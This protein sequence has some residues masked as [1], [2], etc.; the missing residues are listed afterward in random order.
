[1]EKKPSLNAGAEFK[2]GWWREVITRRDTHKSG[3]DFDAVEPTAAPEV[4][5]GPN[6]AMAVSW[7]I[8]VA[9][10]WAWRLLVIVA[11]LALV[12]FGMTKV[13]IIFV[14]LAV[15]LLMTLLLEPLHFWLQK[16][17]VPKTL[18]AVIS[19][20]VGVGLVAAIVS[21]ATTQLASGA[22]ALI[23]KAAGG[24]DKLI[25]WLSE[26][27]LALDQ[28]DIDKYMS[29]LYAQ[30]T[31]LITKYSTSIAS[32]ALSVTSSVVSVVTTLL[33]SLFC[34]FFFLKDGR[35][36][37]IWHIRMLPVPAR[38]PVHEA[39]IR[40]WT[41]LKGYIRAQAL[42]ALV[43][44]VF[45]SL[46][47]AILGAGSMTI[48]LA[49]L[50]FIGSFIPIVG[51]LT[52]GTIAVLILLLDK[53]LMAAIIMLIVILAVQQIEGNVLQPMLMSTAVSLH[54]LAVLLAVTA[55]T[56]L[57]GIIGALM[58]VPVVAFVNTVAL[59]LTG[60]DSMPE[61][62]KRHDRIGGP[63]GTI[64]AQVAMSY[65]SGDKKDSKK[66]LEAQ[67]RVREAADAAV[68]AAA[69]DAAPSDAAGDKPTAPEA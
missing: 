26:G 53:G 49:L 20:I 13:S 9:A 39:A 68:A 27:P 41:T 22:P 30:V 23:S 61:M 21:I 40:G 36:I 4:E 43:D 35:Q 54:P 64:H 24:F 63:P 11:L 29:Q 66:V 48:P 58:A 59:Y 67:Q 37:W 25:D 8:R 16:V 50:I 33:L 12:I 57:G 19:L 44:S 46:G 45:I 15:A 18:S 10:S 42:V 65:V 28:A 62:S 31:A 52:T 1:M 5:S 17:H 14:P 38:E 51:A 34:L 56:F 32:S 6:S 3:P 7:R 55:G 2:H 60:H 47:A 69:E